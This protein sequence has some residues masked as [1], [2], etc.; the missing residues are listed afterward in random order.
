MKL[1][2]FGLLFSVLFIAGCSEAN[3]PQSQVPVEQKLIA[4]IEQSVETENQTATQEKVEIKK[5][6]EG[7]K[8]EIKKETPASV[9]LSNDNTYINSAG[10]EVHSP[11]FAPS[12]PVGASARCRDG[13]YS[14]SQSRRGTCSHHGGVEE[15]Y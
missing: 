10:N 3:L 4:P 2:Y 15:W 11:A 12:I 7:I 1:R 14:F 5:K 9:P 13:S 6:V 8:V